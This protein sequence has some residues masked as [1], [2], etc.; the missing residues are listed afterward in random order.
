MSTT[1]PTA[2]RCGG[3]ATAWTGVRGSRTSAASAAT[4]RRIA[5]SLSQT[6]AGLLHET[7]TNSG[8]QY[9]GYCK[10]LQSACRTLVGDRHA[11]RVRAPLVDRHAGD[12][13]DA[14]DGLRRRRCAAAR[15][16][17]QRPFARWRRE[18]GDDHRL[19]LV[20]LHGEQNVWIR[21]LALV[22]D[23]F[24]GEVLAAFRRRAAH[25]A[26]PP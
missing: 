1:S 5:T 12:Q 24:E 19:P 11:K 18:L 20:R 26:G 13:T 2:S 22:L 15:H 25:L 10:Y 3:A 4:T 7:T 17:R 6:L 23:R 16:A 21:L 8:K 9:V 14:H